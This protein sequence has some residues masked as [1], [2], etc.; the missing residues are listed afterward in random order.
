[1][2]SVRNEIFHLIFL[3]KTWISLLQIRNLSSHIGIPDVTYWEHVNQMQKFHTQQ[4]LLA[5]I[6]VTHYKGKSNC[7]ALKEISEINEYKIRKATIEHKANEDKG[8]FLQ[9]RTVPE[10]INN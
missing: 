10:E 5:H 6:C 3:I 9:C 1:M 4:L 8:H 2:L 7:T